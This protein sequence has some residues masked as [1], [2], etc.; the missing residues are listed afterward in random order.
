MPTASVHFPADFVYPSAPDQLSP[1][2]Q[3]LATTLAEHWP[4]AQLEGSVSARLASIATAQSRESGQ[5]RLS[6]APMTIGKSS[7]HVISFST[8]DKSFIVDSLR[9]VLDRHG[10]AIDQSIHPVL[11][12]CRNQTGELD[13]H[14]DSQKESWVQFIVQP[15]NAEQVATLADEFTTVMTRLTSVTGDFSKMIDF[16][17]QLTSTTDVESQS[18]LTWLRGR[19]T[20]HGVICVDDAGELVD[21]SALGLCTTLNTE[22]L[23]K[24]SRPNN[25]VTSLNRARVCQTKLHSTIHHSGNLSM[26]IVPNATGRALLVG[27]FTSAVHQ[28]S[29]KEI[30]IVRERIEAAIEGFR[31][32]R[33][34]HYLK[35]LEHVFET[36]PR[37]LVMQLSVEELSSIGAEIVAVHGNTQTRLIGVQGPLQQFVYA[38]AYVPR[39]HYSRELRLN[40]EKMLRE[41]TGAVDCQYDTQFNSASAMARMLF[42]LE[43]DQPPAVDWTELNTQLV[44]Q[45]EGFE[46]ALLNALLAGCDNERANR[47]FTQ[48]AG[49]LNEF[50]RQRFTPDD[51]VVDLQMIESIVNGENLALQVAAEGDNLRLNI[52]KP[53]SNLPLSDVLPILENMG[54]FVDSERPFQMTFADRALW[55]HE[56]SLR[57][58]QSSERSVEDIAE[59]LVSGFKA[60]YDNKA[61][62]D[63]FNGLLVIANL[64]WR[65][66]STLRAY[67]HYLQQ[68]G[69]SSSNKII[70]EALLRYPHIATMLVELFEFRFNPALASPAK[71]TATRE[72]LTEALGPVSSLEDDRIFSALI[73]LIE[74]TL[75]TNFYQALDG[76]AKSYTSF[77]FDCKRVEGMPEPRPMYEIFVYSPEFEAVH[78]RGG[79]VARGGLRWSDRTS[80]FRT[81]IL[82][83]VKAQMVK[84]AVI[85]PVGSKGGFVLTHTPVERDARMSHGIACYQNFLRGL[86]DITDNLNG[87]EVV[88][89]SQV[90]RH[91]GDDPY[92]VVAADKGTATFSDYA[93]AVSEEYGFWLGDAFASGGSNGYDHKGMGITAKG[94][95]ESVKR[96]FREQ[97]VNTQTTDFTVVGVGDMGGDVFGNGMLLS[98]HIQL[99]GAF[100]HLH[101]FIDPAPDSANSYQERLRLFTTP[102]SSW[103]DYNTE[104]M[105][106]GGAIYERSAKSITLSDEAMQALGTDRKQFTPD[107]LINTM[108]KAPVDLIW[109]GGIGTYIKASSETHAQ[110]ADRSNDS[111]RVDANQVRAK[112]IGEG[113]N[114][115]VTQRARIELAECGVH[116]YTDAVDNSAGV[117]CS[118]HEV[119]IKILLQHAISTGTLLDADRNQL[120][121]D[122]TDE[123]SELVLK[124]N[125]QQTQCISVCNRQAA[126][127]IDQH[128]RFMEHL[129]RAGQLNRAIEFLPNSDLI[130]E[131]KAK[132]LGLMRP[133]LAVL[134]SY[135][136]MTLFA[137][138]MQGSLCS[139]PAFDEVLQDYFPDRLST[140]LPTSVA[141]HRLRNEII[142]TVVTNDFINR[143]GPSFAWQ[144]H[145]E[146]GASAQDVVRAYWAVKSMFDLDTLWADVERL[147]NQVSAELQIELLVFSQGLAERATQWLLRRRG[148]VKDIA[149]LIAEF[150][151]SISRISEQL[152]DLMT[153]TMLQK[154]HARIDEL[155]TQG[156]P[157]EMRA[158]FARIFPMSSAL[159][160]A[161]IASS[162]QVD[163]VDAAKLHMQLGDHLQLQW[164]RDEIAKLQ[165]SSHWHTIAKAK[166]RTDLHNK[167]R[168]LSAMIL[169]QAG[170]LD[171]WAQSASTQVDQ[172]QRILSDLAA[173]GDLDFA[174]LSLAS[175]A[176]GELIS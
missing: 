32:N 26:V 134:V 92:L 106:K 98:E 151:P 14:G 2:S 118:D 16:I 129:E 20:F 150:K 72:A 80:D 61:Q 130:N 100:N 139:D 170:S 10:I 101:I 38:I 166:L 77:K 122:M 71:A 156:V 104:L 159:D 99:V 85:V 34:Q 46:T 69:F 154:Y 76:Q 108:L 5:S 168:D 36:L 65:H 176:V 117:D 40:T 37:E 164:L 84:N 51:A 23:A 59:H 142:G 15:L 123:V 144:M 74:S 136:K 157:V 78:L 43:V 29:V 175:S 67:S 39:E 56:F 88:H 174:M 8:G 105:S 155:K 171:A 9:M 167:Q 19:F 135:A 70:A 86:L 41:A 12:I 57:R 63:A 116:C 54:L 81:E 93:N 114:L 87:D 30:P 91:D 68:L 24:L 83:L 140:D 47:L 115:G 146:L 119:N 133:E 66:V 145:S 158:K 163:V 143:M 148:D 7:R 110:A 112:V 161:E 107:E 152:V 33:G 137:E 17:D 25:H 1:Y 162:S 95:W 113:G 42:T 21:D 6:L 73:N 13:Q 27:Q 125:Y 82:G 52:W 94:A 55:L 79:P 89:P 102:G 165:T 172:Y 149:E 4:S 31:H 35:S 109:N 60:T 3:Q 120:L 58:K 45:T 111:T 28:H 22:E 96:H 160:W 141:S 64:H 132:R 173:S 121:A 50:Y 127:R 153:D 75:R 169:T 62:N 128:V 97:G 124:D 147:D 126:G 18:F 11:D 44:Q 138:L 48:Y 90:I 131:R 49:V 103:T 53:D